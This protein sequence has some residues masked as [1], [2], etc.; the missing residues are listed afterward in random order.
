LERREEKMSRE[1]HTHSKSR[2]EK[3]YFHSENFKN[4][5]KINNIGKGWFF[6]L[7]S[8]MKKNLGKIIFSENFDV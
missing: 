7:S 1:I 4:T 5:T 8:Q 2:K 3:S 6:F